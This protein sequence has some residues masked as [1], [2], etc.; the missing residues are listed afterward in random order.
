MQVCFEVSLVFATAAFS[1]SLFFFSLF[2]LSFF[3]SVPNSDKVWGSSER[4]FGCVR[5][6]TILLSVCLCVREFFFLGK[7]ALFFTTFPRHR[8]KTSSFYFEK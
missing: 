7:R 5:L 3:F 8:N 6:H 2:F 1:I 4:V